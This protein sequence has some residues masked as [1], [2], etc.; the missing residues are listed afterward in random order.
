MRPNSTWL[1]AIAIVV[2]TACS[3]GPRKEPLALEEINS[4]LDKASVPRPTT[5]PQDA[6][7]QS[8]LP[9]AATTEM[10]RERD[11]LAQRFDLTVTN[12][13][14]PQVLN[15]LVNGTRY[16]MVI[17]PGVT[18]PVS[19]S[20]RE[21]TIPEVLNSMRELYGYDY[22]IEGTLIYVLPASLQTQLFKVE[23]LTQSRRGSTDMRVSS[24]AV[25]TTGTTNTGGGGGAGAAAGGAGAR[26][27][28]AGA[29]GQ[30]TMVETNSSSDFWREMF[31]S[32]SVLVGC[33]PQGPGQAPGAAPGAP[34]QSMATE[35]LGCEGANGRRLIVSP[36]SGTILVRAMPDELR[37][38]SRYLRASQASVERQVLIEAKILEVALKDGYETGINWAAF[39]T[40]N[41]ETAG[42]GLLT[43]GAI[44]GTTGTGVIPSGNTAARA[45]PTPL[46]A[47]NTLTGAPLGAA[48]RVLEAAGAATGSIFGIA[49]QGKNFAALMTFLD[50]QGVVHTLS[51]PRIAT[52]NNQKAVLKVGTDQLFVTRITGGQ[53]Q[54]TAV[55]TAPTITSPTFEVQSFFSGIALDVTPRI[56]EDGAILLHVRPSVTDVTQQLSTFN[57]GVLGSFTIPLVANQVSETDSVIRATDGQ[58]VAIGG[59][60]RAAQK[61]NRNQV[62]GVGDVPFLG[63]AFRNVAQSSEKREL[64]ILLKPTI[65]QGDETWAR[66]NLEMRDRV[67]TMERG[68]SWGGRAEVFGTER[69]GNWRPPQ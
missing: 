58:I 5:P 55:G 14:A 61:E 43:P 45:F 11:D 8:L 19:L 54:G 57:L 26:G 12:A 39:F 65:V 47:G 21:V 67:R 59:L 9:P 28:G 29:S 2:L 53:S 68:F 15:A 20:L 63:G 35:T 25:M 4:V 3:M 24:N 6:I 32:V 18:Q 64:V 41:G 23:Y 51:S 22:R 40:R 37:N 34:A 44:L 31:M 49:I 7:L 36:Q 27:G 69:E 66:N 60:M 42:I 46:T 16:S 56:G 17:H 38:V 10:P 30:S 52:M 33:T 1:S 48:G 62:P 13:P 50:S